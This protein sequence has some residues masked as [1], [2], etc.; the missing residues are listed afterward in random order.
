MYSTNVNIEI[1]HRD[2]YV[3]MIAVRGT[4]GLTKYLFIEMRQRFLTN[5]S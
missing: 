5:T 3:R 2:L 4:Q 1:V